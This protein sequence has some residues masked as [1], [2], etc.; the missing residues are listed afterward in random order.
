MC[1]GLKR[2]WITKTEERALV[3][4]IQNGLRLRD[5]IWFF[6]KPTRFLLF[7][8]VFGQVLLLLVSALILPLFWCWEEF[9]HGRALMIE[10]HLLWRIH[11]VEDILIIIERSHDK[12]PLFEGR[13]W[14]RVPIVLL[15][16]ASSIGLILRVDSGIANETPPPRIVETSL[17]W[18][19]RRS[20]N[21]L[22]LALKLFLLLSL[23]RWH[24]QNSSRRRL[25]VS[26]L[27]CTLQSGVWLLLS[28][29]S[30]SSLCQP[31]LHLQLLGRVT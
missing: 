1:R 27:H 6:K 11:A 12:W 14:N 26:H 15:G 9:N 5:G 8:R 13:L 28:A 23:S 25:T 3:L 19:F 29:S 17:V 30:I 10:H 22:L 4:L 21:R 16:G 31:R 24:S 2:A 7:C 18:L 20:N